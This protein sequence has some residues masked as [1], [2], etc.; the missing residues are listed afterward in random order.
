MLFGKLFVRKILRVCRLIHKGIGLCKDALVNNA[1]N[2]SY[3]YRNAK[4]TEKHKKKLA[5][6]KT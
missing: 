3:G 2:S 1:I 6:G 4:R 5:Q